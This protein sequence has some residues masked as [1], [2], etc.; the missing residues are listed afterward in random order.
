MADPLMNPLA[1][2]PRALA[3]PR[4]PSVSEGRSPRE[5][6]REFEGLL[7][8]QLFQTLRKTVEPSGLFGE[9]GQARS[10][11]EYLL[12][13]A[14][15]QH[16]MNTGRGWGLAERLEQAWAQREEKAALSGSAGGDLKDSVSVP[17]GTLSR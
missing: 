17:I 3:A 9:E 15:V 7:M 1:L 16:A 4:L 10:T 12:D 8:A 6:A 5:A 2:D 11:Y 13:Q 14:V